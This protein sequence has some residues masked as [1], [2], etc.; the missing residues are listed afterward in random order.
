MPSWLVQYSRSGYYRQYVLSIALAL[1][2]VHSC[3]TINDLEA[4]FHG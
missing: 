2:Q 1:V 4:Q 3:Y